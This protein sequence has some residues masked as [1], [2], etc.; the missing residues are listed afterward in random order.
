MANGLARQLWGRYLAPNKEPSKPKRP[1]DTKS[2]VQIR[3]R[4][5]GRRRSARNRSSVASS[6]IVEILAVT[7][8][9]SEQVRCPIL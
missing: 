3:I 2:L 1:L 8:V 5:T 6:V 4:S 7:L 9:N